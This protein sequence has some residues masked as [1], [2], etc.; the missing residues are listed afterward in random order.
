MYKLIKFKFTRYYNF[1]RI[2][3]LL[4]CYEMEIIYGHLM[5]ILIEDQIVLEI[6]D[7]V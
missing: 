7:L 3:F 2:V 4:I 1:A 5:Y 6:K